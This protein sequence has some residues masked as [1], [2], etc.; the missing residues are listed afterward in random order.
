MAAITEPL[1]A[2][3]IVFSLGMAATSLFSGYEIDE[4]EAKM[5][6]R[7]LLGPFCLAVVILAVDGVWDHWYLI[8]RL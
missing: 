4:V 3:A 7:L 8:W 5:A 2:A 1:I 6:F